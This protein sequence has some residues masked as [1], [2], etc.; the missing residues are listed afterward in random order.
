MSLKRL[1]STER[2]TLPIETRASIVQA[3]DL[4]RRREPYLTKREIVGILEG[5]ILAENPS[6]GQLEDFRE[7]MRRIARGG[8][9]NKNES[10]RRTK[11]MRT[12]KRRRTIKNR[13][14]RSKRSRH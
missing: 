9:R 13:S 8:K 1:F 12:R 6:R 4:I 7:M 10:A 14:G 5:K 2:K 11:K 3:Y